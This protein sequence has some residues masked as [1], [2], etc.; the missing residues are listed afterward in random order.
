MHKKWYDVDDNIGEFPKT[1]RDFTELKQDL[2]TD[3][4]VNSADASRAVG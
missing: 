2:I 1:V 3:A 4:V